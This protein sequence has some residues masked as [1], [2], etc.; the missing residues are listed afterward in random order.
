MESLTWLYR[1]RGGFMLV[2]VLVI[3][4]VGIL[5][6]AGALLLFRFQC[7]RRIE[8]QH[9]LEKV[10]AVR[11]AV[12]YTRTCVGE[13]SE[14][15]KDFRFCTTSGRDL[16]LTVKPVAPVFPDSTKNHFT[17]ENGHFEFRET[18][19]DVFRDYEYGAIGVTNLLMSKMDNDGNWGLGIHDLVATNNVRWW[20]NI[21]MRDTGGWLQEDYGRRYYFHPTDYVEGSVSRN[22]MVR[23]ALIRNVTNDTNAVGRRHGW[24]LS[25]E[26]ERAIVFAM[27]PSAHPSD[28]DNGNGDMILSEMCFSG[29]E[30]VTREVLVLT[31]TPSMCYMGMQLAN[32]KLTCFYVDIKK[33]ASQ[34]FSTVGY[35]FADSTELSCETYDYFADGIYTNEYGQLKAPE[36]RAVFEFEAS[37]D[38]RG[39]GAAISGANLD[40]LT[41]FRVTP[42][43]QYDIYLEHPESEVNLATVAQKIGSYTRTGSNYSMLTYDTHGTEHKG[44][45]RDERERERRNAR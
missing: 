25:R 38:A 13:I 27:K 24:P 16:G 11:S 26:G 30:I 35:N 4:A 7:E 29:G 32:D 20:V 31:N 41:D 43:Y 3:T 19:Y 22:D 36:L 1:A 39:E 18:Q 42:A 34:D 6:G 14:E 5:F 21:G 37:S 10:Y 8:R 40:F 17:M 23:L 28:A 15:G 33:A 2:T 9:E 12:N 45:R 44:F